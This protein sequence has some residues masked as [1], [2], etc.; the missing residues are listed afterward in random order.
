MIEELEKKTFNFYQNI[1]SQQNLKQHPFQNQ[2]AKT[3][4]LS[5]CW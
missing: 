4:F 3:K 1:E 5:S 2:T